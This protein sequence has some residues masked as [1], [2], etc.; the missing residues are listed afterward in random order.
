[1]NARRLIWNSLVDA[2]YE[3]VPL[4]VTN[5]LWVI[6][7][8]PVITAPP[9]AAG[10]Y[11][12]TNQLA[13]QKSVTWRTFF[14]GF[15]AHFWL[16]WRWGLVNLLVFAILGFNFW[17]YGRGETSWGVWLQ[18]AFLGMMVLWGLLQLYTFPLL[19]EQQDRRMRTALRNSL[20]LFLRYPA[21]S[22]GLALLVALLVV[23]STLFLPPFWLLFTASL[24]AY[25][26]NRGTIDLIEGLQNTPHR[27]A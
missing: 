16:G 13:Q 17:F 19:L 1:M 10:L 5:V 22:I 11:Y 8:L 27:G 4:I 18:G 7:T 3:S 14:E 23:V 15:R 24:S 12:A 9:A 21:F 6:L 20:V 26:A 2:Y 25:L